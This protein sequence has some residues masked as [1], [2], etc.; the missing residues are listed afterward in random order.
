MLNE[1]ASSG[2]DEALDHQLADNLPAGRTDGE[3]DR[4]LAG[5]G[6]AAGQQHV[7]EIET[8]DDQH[9]PGHG[10]EQGAQ[11]VDRAVII[12]RRADAEAGG[13]EHLQFLLVPVRGGG[14]EGVDL[15]RQ[16]GQA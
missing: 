10:E 2:E 7:G 15:R 16:G 9:D 8:G 11:Q 3:A 5:A 14:L 4:H 1:A 12:G 13:R 6:R